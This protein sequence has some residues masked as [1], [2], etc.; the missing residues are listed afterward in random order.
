[1]VLKPESF[2]HLEMCDPGTFHLPTISNPDQT[3]QACIL[4]TLGINAIYK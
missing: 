4:P 2:L 1:L 3:D